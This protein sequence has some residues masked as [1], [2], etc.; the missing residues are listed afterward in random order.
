MTSLPTCFYSYLFSF[1]F[2]IVW[3]QFIAPSDIHQNWYCT[4]WHRP[5]QE[6]NGAISRS[7]TCSE[8]K[9]VSI[10]KSICTFHWSVSDINHNFV[11]FTVFYLGML[12]FLKV[13]K[14]STVLHSYAPSRCFSCTET[15]LESILKVDFWLWQNLP[16]FDVSSHSTEDQ[17][18]WGGRRLLQEMD[19]SSLEEMEREESKNCTAP[20]KTETGWKKED[21]QVFSPSLQNRGRKMEEKKAVKAGNKWSP[22]MFCLSTLSGPP[23]FSS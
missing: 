20:G 12:I 2:H 11:N 6:F 21:T 8:L 7:V 4:V 10:T 14:K 9:I 22:H 15:S 17:E 18:R 19:N 5:D 13:M 23:V 16:G 3:L 1:S